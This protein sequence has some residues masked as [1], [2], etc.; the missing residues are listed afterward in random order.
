MALSLNPATRVFTVLQADLTFVSG[1]LYSLDTNQLRK[2]MWDLL[3]SEPYIW[4]PPA[5]IHN[6]E[7]T[8]A[9]VT[10]A[11]TLELI[12]S[13][14]I[15]LENTGSAYTVNFVG[16]NNNFFDIENGILNPT[17]LVT[18]QSNNSAGL[19]TVI[20][21]S[22]LSVD[23]AAQLIE[24]WRLLGLEAGNKITITPSGVDDDNATIDINF[25]GD[26]I[27]T[28]VMERKP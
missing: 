1:T 5:F 23:Q 6:T 4:M 26:G 19:Q 28:T 2:D 9:G 12:N 27:S 11:R 21:G 20:S 22:G 10:Y 7:V 13:Y 15:T 24:I 18:V 25:T 17:S 16:S 3:S 14:S 8:V